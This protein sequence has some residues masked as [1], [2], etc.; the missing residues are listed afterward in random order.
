M[1]GGG[2]LSNTMEVVVEGSDDGK[3]KQRVRHGEEDEVWG[4]S[5][6]KVQQ[7]MVLLC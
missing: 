7:V 1:S 5:L 6:K 3:A 2:E 4:K